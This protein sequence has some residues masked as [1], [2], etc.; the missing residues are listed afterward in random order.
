MRPKQSHQVVESRVAQEITRLVNAS[1]KSQY[2]ISLE[3]G[4]SKSN[5]I[6]MLKRKRR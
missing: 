2:E 5:F 4:L 1:E 3:M 6:T